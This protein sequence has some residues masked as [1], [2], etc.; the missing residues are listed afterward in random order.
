MRRYVLIALLTLFC[1]S[2]F[3][4]GGED[5]SEPDIRDSLKISTWLLSESLEGNGRFTYSPDPPDYGI[6]LTD[7]GKEIAADEAFTLDRLELNKP[8]VL[9][10]MGFQFREHINIRFDCDGIVEIEAM[11]ATRMSV[12]GTALILR[13]NRGSARR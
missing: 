10:P 2:Q 12:C 13:R 1:L 11:R 9:A 5:I 6:W 4:C 7:D 8:R 3:S